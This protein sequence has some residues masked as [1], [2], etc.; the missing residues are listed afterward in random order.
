MKTESLRETR[1][2]DNLSLSKNVSFNLKINFSYTIFLWIIF[3]S[4]V[5]FFIYKIDSTKTDDFTKNLEI[6]KFFFILIG[7]GI[8]ILTIYIQA[9]T[10]EKTL[11]LMQS[12]E[13][14]EKKKISLS[15]LAKWDSIEFKERREFY[16]SMRVQKQ[17]CGISDFISSI[18]N[19]QTFKNNL[20]DIANFFE[21]IEQAII[22]DIADEPILK[23]GFQPLVSSINS[24][25]YDWFQNLKSTDL[26]YYNQFMPF[27]NLLEKW[28]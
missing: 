15:Y 22:H 4:I 3:S 1:K 20:I 10:S 17:E 25:F 16:R 18:N 24:T 12:Q 9:V 2:I 28:K 8:A 21:D 23:N 11:Q 14:I 7:A 5:S 26:K 27:F 6:A 19:N 13:D